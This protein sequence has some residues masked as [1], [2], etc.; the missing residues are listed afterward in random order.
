[1]L[2]LAALRDNTYNFFLLLHLLAGIVGL[3][4][5]IAGLVA[6]RAAGADWASVRAIR[7]VY[8]PAVIVTG[9]LGIVLVLL[10][11]DAWEFSQAW[12]SLAFLVWI[13]M[14]GV[15]QAVVLRGARV[16]GVDG[17]RRAVLGAQVLSALLVVQLY[18]MVFKPGA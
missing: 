12:I 6:P 18:L 10:S 8:A 14:V 3:A 13:A 4:A 11:D 9:L 15:Y 17:A 16:G 1:V 2:V 5:A 7:I